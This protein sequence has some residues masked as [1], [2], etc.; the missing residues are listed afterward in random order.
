[1][2]PSA[3]NR[4]DLDFSPGET[5]VTGR[6]RQLADGAH[7]YPEFDVAEATAEGQVVRFFEQAFEWNNLTYLFYPYFWGRKSR[8][9]DVFP[10][11]DPDP[12]FRDF[13]RAGSAR[14]PARGRPPGLQ[15]GRAALH[16]HQ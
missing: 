5:E 11:D 14:V 7:G 16:Q 8:W 15:R 9:L 10:L 1:M 12:Q 3:T 6:Q 13:L 4:Q 2:W